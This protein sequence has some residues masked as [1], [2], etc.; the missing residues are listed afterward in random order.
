MGFP[1]VA[2][3][4]VSAPSTGPIVAA[5]AEKGHITV[6]TIIKVITVIK[7]T[8]LFIRSVFIPVYPVPSSIFRFP[9]FPRIVPLQES[10]L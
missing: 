9:S 4:V 5:D 3:T 1:T 7:C 8:F 6:I 2:D 10:P